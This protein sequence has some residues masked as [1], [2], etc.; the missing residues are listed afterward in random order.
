MADPFTPGFGEFQG[1]P[2]R[3]IPDEVVEYFVFAPNVTKDLRKYLQEVKTHADGLLRKHGEGYIWQRE[4]LKLEIEDVEETTCL[5]GTTEF[6]DSI[7]DEWFVVYLLRELSIKFPDIWVRVVDADGEFLLVEAA[8]TLPRWLNPEIA[9]HRVWINSGKLYIIPLSAEQRSSKGK[10][11]ISRS[12]TLKEGLDTIR[13]PKDDVKLLHS[14]LIQEEAF[15][16]ISKYPEAAQ[17]HMHHALVRIPL[18]VA[19]ILHARPDLVSAAVEAFYIRDPISLQACAGMPDFPP[20]T[21]V[22]TSVKFSKVLYAQLRGQEFE[23]PAEFGFIIPEEDS[24]IYTQSDVGMKL[25]IGFQILAKD[26]MKPE[27]SEAVKALVKYLPDP[28][29]DTV[30]TWSKR[31]DGEG[32][33]DVDYAEFEEN[34]KGNNSKGKGKGGF[35]DEDANEKIRKMVANFEKML[36]DETAGPEGAEFSDDEEEDEM[37]ED[38]DTDDE[39]EEDGELKEIYVS[40]SDED[41][42][43]SFDEKEFHQMMREMMGLPPD[44]AAA[45]V[46]GAEPSSS[47]AIQKQSD[48]ARESAA[49]KEHMDLVGAE[50]R[51]AGAISDNDSD[52]DEDG[53]LDIDYNL[54]KNLLESFKSQGGMPGPAGNLLARMGIVLPRDEGDEVERRG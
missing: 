42:E 44:M 51:Q 12:L 52:E 3:S 31:Q 24:P 14:D 29:E 45:G 43:V 41:K 6:G 36:N 13:K 48:E 8:N 53:E 10:G 49:I 5:H 16:R 7:D 2:K 4:K 26:S 20:S 38:D 30:N 37:D 1:I 15:Y 22:I 21:S 54:A 32:W 23:P 18:G 17:D 27:T 25:A 46:E 34:L 9:D 19:K 35:A 33:L 47:T 39:D 28:S 11:G 50:L 40:D